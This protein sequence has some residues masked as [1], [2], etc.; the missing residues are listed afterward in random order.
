MG[1][2]LGRIAMKKIVTK[3]RQPSHLEHTLALQLRALSVPTP[4]TEYRFHPVRRWRFD[5]AWPELQLAVEVE[6]GAW[7]GGRHTRG[8]GFEADLE[9]YHEAMTAGWTLYRCGRAL[10]LSGQAAQLVAMLVDR[11]RQSA[12]HKNTTKHDMLGERG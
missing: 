5:M 11:L 2:K 8:S 12:L 10:V 1:K 3:Q 4:L 6:G 9:K 7:T